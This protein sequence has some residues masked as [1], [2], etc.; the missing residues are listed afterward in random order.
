MRPMRPMR[1]AILYVLPNLG[2]VI[3]SSIGGRAIA[4][5]KQRSPRLTS[6]AIE[7]GIIVLHMRDHKPG[8]GLARA[9]VPKVVKYE[10]VRGKLRKIGQE[11]RPEA[12]KR[13][14][15]KASSESTLTG[16]GGKEAALQDSKLSWNL[17][18]LSFCFPIAR[19]LH[20][21]D[22]GRPS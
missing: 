3:L 5:A 18:P 12:T 10:L 7:S 8:G 21:Q 1:I 2:S 6:V 13:M 16:R 9:T 14:Q 11:S 19:N 4:L 22:L 17:H 20:R 15:V